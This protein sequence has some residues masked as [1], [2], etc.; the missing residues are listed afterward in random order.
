[1]NRTDLQQL[2]ELRLEDSRVLFQNGRYAAAY[3]L[4][5]YAVECG[6]KACIAQQIIQREYSPYANFSRD[7][8]THDLNRLVLL[9]NLGPALAA[10]RQASP[11]FA[12][13]WSEVEQWSEQSRYENWTRQDAQ[14]LL[15]AVSRVPDGVLEWIR[16]L[17]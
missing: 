7:L 2:A 3:Y 16:Q 4:C 8:F 15:D 14:R 6:L 9:A 13:N 5:G 10:R 1:V 17:W 12:R 11:G